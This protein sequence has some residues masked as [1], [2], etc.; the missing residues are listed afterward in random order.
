MSER[1]TMELLSTCPP[2]ADDD[3]PPS[4]DGERELKEDAKKRSTKN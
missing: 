2:M 3:S 1:G 4:F